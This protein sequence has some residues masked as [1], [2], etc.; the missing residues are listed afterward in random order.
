ML[1]ILGRAICIFPLVSIINQF[2]SEPIGYKYQ[3][4][5]W[6]SGLRGPV[7]F[8]LAFSVPYHNSLI[9]TSTLMIIFATTIGI[10]GV[11]LPVLSLLKLTQGP[12]EAK[13]FPTYSEAHQGE[14]EGVVMSELGEKVDVWWEK[15][16]S[17]NEAF[18]IDKK[19]K[20]GL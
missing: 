19:L 7:A 20:V 3:L 10:G 8:A 11:T 2:R 18:V 12:S 9:L 14:L 6:L 13:I 15:D 1:C 4:V 5:M 16:G 17:W